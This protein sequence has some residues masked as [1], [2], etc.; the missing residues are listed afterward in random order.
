MLN[1]WLLTNSKHH[2]MNHKHAHKSKK[3]VSPHRYLRE[4][5][6][7]LRRMVPCDGKSPCYS[8]ENSPIFYGH[9]FNGYFDNLPKRYVSMFFPP[10]WQL[11]YPLRMM[12]L[13]FAMQQFTRGYVVPKDFLGVLPPLLHVPGVPGAEKL[14]HLHSDMGGPALVCKWQ[15]FARVEYDKHEESA[16]F[17]WSMIYDYLWLIIYDYLWL[18]TM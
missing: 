16:L 11:T 7:I 18:S 4:F 14:S 15:D 1:D 8:W 17:W 9:G 3:Q 10:H 5:N 13:Q 6:R 2:P 12:S